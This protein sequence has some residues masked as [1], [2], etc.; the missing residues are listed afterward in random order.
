MLQMSKNWLQ[1]GLVMTMCT[2]LAGTAWSPAH[3]INPSRVC[4]PI[5]QYLP[6]DEPE[7]SSTFVERLSSGFYIDWTGWLRVTANELEPVIDSIAD[8]DIIR[9][10]VIKPTPD[11]ILKADLTLRKDG[12]VVSMVIDGQHC[13]ARRKRQIIEGL[14]LPAFPIGSEL[15]SITVRFDA[16]QHQITVVPQLTQVA[17]TDT[18][19]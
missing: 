1:Y 10:A 14:R 13:Y 6:T 15:S 5:N 19:H 18:V 16:T 11:T 7:A 9:T 17:G 2:T 12:R 8:C 3:A 4:P